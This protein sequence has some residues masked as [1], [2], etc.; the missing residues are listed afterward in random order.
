VNS[1]S[2]INF[3]KYFANYLRI[4][5]SDPH[6]QRVLAFL[7]SNRTFT[8]YYSSQSQELPMSEFLQRCLTCLFLWCKFVSPSPKTQGGG[9]QLVGCLHLLYSVNSYT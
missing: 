3:N 4:V 1:C 2:S 6:L 7:V 5:F 9:S 8:F